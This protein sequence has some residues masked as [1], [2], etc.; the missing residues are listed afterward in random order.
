M[1]AAFKNQQ[2]IVTDSVFLQPELKLMKMLNFAQNT[3]LCLKLKTKHASCS[4]LLSN[5]FHCHCLLCLQTWSHI[6]R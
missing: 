5:P 3:T 4:E 1:K 6:C 2:H